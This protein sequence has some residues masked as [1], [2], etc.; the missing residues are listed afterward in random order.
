VFEIMQRRKARDLELEALTALH[1]YPALYCRS[2]PGIAGGPAAAIDKIF[3]E[4]LLARLAA[5]PLWR[6]TFITY[7]WPP[8]MILWGLGLTAV[9]GVFVA[10]H[11]GR[12][13]LRQFADQMRLAFGQGIPVPFFYVY[14]L[15]EPRNQAHAQ[16]FILRGQIKG[17][18]QLYKRL[19]RTSPERRDSAR[20]LNDK[21]AFHRF[22]SARNLPVAHLFA[23]VEKKAIFWRD[24]LRRTLPPIDLFIKPAKEC[25]GT[26]A[27]RWVYAD[28]LYHGHKGDR[29]DAASLIEHIQHLSC[30]QTYLAFECLTN[31]PEIH[32]LS[33]GAL[34]TLRMHTMLNERGEAEHLFSMFRMSQFRQRIIDT[35]DGIAASVDPVTGLLGMASNSS[36]MARWYDRHPFTN[37]RI[38]GR[39]VPFWQDAL[40][41]AVSTHQALASPYVVGWDIAVTDRGPVILEANKSPDLEIEQRLNGSWANGRFGELLAYHL[42]AS[43]RDLKAVVVQGEP[44]KALQD[45]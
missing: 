32:D 42:T 14:E 33:A 15:H 43:G 9:N 44:A 35:S 1:A 5:M 38:T 41:L 11:Y 21:L 7:I 25:G 36:H 18:G 8:A 6:R 19:Y 16:E 23:V 12:G 34:S 10:R 26:G 13:I 31:H 39:R 30:R 37:A 27:E 17:G 24:E 29:R 2:H 20:I 40:K 22:L 45:A 3:R 28:G 4:E